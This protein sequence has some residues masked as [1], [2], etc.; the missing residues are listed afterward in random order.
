MSAP[1]SE[2]AASTQFQQL[3][4]AAQETARAQYFDTVV[5]PKIPAAELDK[6]RAQFD[7]QTKAAPAKG[8]AGQA[9][10]TTTP[11]SS[12]DLDPTAITSQYLIKS[13][14]RGMASMLGLPAETAN[15]VRNMLVAGG[16]TALHAAGIISADQLPTLD[17]HPMFGDE[18]FKEKIGAAERGKPPDPVTRFVGNALEEAVPMTMGAGGSLGK[19]IT[20]G[21]ELTKKL[22]GLVTVAGTS[23]SASAGV[24]EMFPDSPVGGVL[25]TLVGA[26]IFPAWLI[27]RTKLASTVLT[28]E[29]RADMAKKTQD[30]LDPYVESKAANQLK[31]NLGQTPNVGENIDEA[32]KLEKAIPGLTF[33][34]GQKTN[35]AGVIANEK[36]ASSATGAGVEGVKALQAAQTNAILAH[37][38]PAQTTRAGTPLTSTKKAIDNV[39]GVQ[40]ETLATLKAQEAQ[41]RTNEARKIEAMSPDTTPV[42][43][44]DAIRFQAAREKGIAD[45]TTAK[46]YN[47]GR[48]EAQTAHAGGPARFNPEGI[49]ETKN[50]IMANPLVGFD[51]KNAPGVIKQLDELAT[52]E[53]TKI[54]DANGKEI[55]KPPVMSYDEVAALDTAVNQDILAVKSLQGN[56]NARQQLRALYDLK[57]SIS[58]A[59]V[60][61]PY[62]GVARKWSA[63]TEYYKND[64]APR[65]LNGANLKM[66]LVDNLGNDRIV[67]EK[68]LDTYIDNSGNTRRFVDLFKDNAIAQNTMKEH[69]QDTYLNDV[70]RNGEFSDMRHAKFMNENADVFKQLERAQPGITK[71][72]ENSG[73]FL[74]DMANRRSIAAQNQKAIADS[75]LARLLKTEDTSTII[76]TAMKSPESMGRLSAALGEQ[77]SRSLMRSVMG[78][79]FETLQSKNRDKLGIDSSAFREWLAGNEKQLSV[80]ARQAYGPEAGKEY[81]TNLKQAA[82]A[83]EIQERVALPTSSAEVNIGNDPLKQQVGITTRT[84]FNLYRAVIGGRTSVEDAAIALGGQ[85]ASHILTQRFNALQQSLLSD[86]ARTK[87][88][89]T[90]IRAGTDVSGTSPKAY[91]KLLGHAG[92]YWMGGQFYQPNMAIAMPAIAAQAASSSGEQK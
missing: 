11:E 75:E 55:T 22:I 4:P 41:L 59:I 20:S 65:F 37:I 19:G 63:A 76:S 27:A 92:Y 90:A 36:A 78:Q 42:D 3:D 54:L 91:M 52:R 67:T 24:K 85:A 12:G 81:V 56:P 5:K 64:Y 25:G 60:N 45:Q 70:M 51:P 17:T 74:Q 28:K 80:V 23:G 35:S 83:L 39:I 40:D 38:D 15:N 10:L 57:G 26:T 89:L 8:T 1:W 72:F 43:R 32:T 14:G 2:V 47:D 13:A 58:D 16:A 88:L 62:E 87:D 33:T 34:A 6:A 84:V 50:K 61:S 7:A 30:L 29:G 9:G 68:L 31:Q 53:G 79:A 73:N 48:L 21:A 18:W 71:Y 46:L 82:R 77:G 66:R 49:V 86:P 69:L 44:A